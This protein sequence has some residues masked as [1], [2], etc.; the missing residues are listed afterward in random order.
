MRRLAALMRTLA[1]PIRDDF[2]R[3]SEHVYTI[4]LQ[5]I[6]D[7]RIRPGERLV[8]DEIA[9]QLN[10]SRTPIRDALSRLV[11]EGLVQ[12]RG[13]RGLYMTSLSAE[14]LANLFELRRMCELFAV[15]KGTTT[16]SDEIIDKMQA[17][18][19]EFVRLANSED[20]AARVSYTLQDRELHRLLVSLG[21]NPALSELFERLSIHT[22][23]LRAG[24]GPGA[25]A[26]PKA[27]QIEHAEILKALRRRDTTATVE[28]TRTHLINAET[29][30]VAA[31]ESEQ[32]G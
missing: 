32:F 17:A 27:N 28:A 25:P 6:A 30:A 18:A 31:L 23:S 3:L 7:H 20:P 11:A 26:I 29:R 22:H 16:A 15:E 24:L 2:R 10:V 13:R 9:A 21:R 4:I 5:A 19:D 1:P 12:P 14:E 8:L